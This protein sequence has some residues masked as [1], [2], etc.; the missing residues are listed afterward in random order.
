MMEIVVFSVVMISL[1]VI[2]RALAIGRF[3]KVTFVMIWGIIM[4]RLL[5]PVSF[6]IPMPFDVWNIFDSRGL[7]FGAGES[8]AQV[9]DAAS[10]VTS[11]EGQSFVLVVQESVQSS[12]SFDWFFV[13]WLVGVVIGIFYFG[14]SHYRFRNDVA[15]SL[16]VENEFVSKWLDG[17]SLR[18]KI[19]VRQSYKVSSPLTYGVIRPIILMPKVM[20]WQDEEQLRYVLTHEYVHIRRFDYVSKVLLSLVLCVYWF[21]PFVWVMYVLANRDI[22]L[23]CDEAVLDIL[24]QN[25]RKMYALTLLSLKERQGRY[26]LVSNYFSKNFLEE[27]VSLMMSVKKKSILGGCLA[28]VVVGGLTTIFANANAVPEVDPVLDADAGVTGVLEES[29]GYGIEGRQVEMISTMTNGD[30]EAGSLEIRMTDDGDSAEVEFDGII[31]DQEAVD[32]DIFSAWMEEQ[33]EMAEA[34]GDSAESIELD[35]ERFMQTLSHI[36]AGARVFLVDNGE[37]GHAILT[38]FSDDADMDWEF[39]DTSFVEIRE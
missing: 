7:L 22:E 36:E 19:Q 34:R 21:N 35:R 33:L 4:A 38:N 2:I 20:D 31:V 24:G 26:S 5:I 16:P 29:Y 12:S 10:L 13:V 1:V 37:N 8:Y 18:R 3:P 14:L 32:Y 27:R 23:A 15:D 25:S 28:L 6:S 9:S 11:S 30:S 39:S 17:S